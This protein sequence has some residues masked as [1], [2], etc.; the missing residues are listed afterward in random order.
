MTVPT[1]HHAPGH[2][3]LAILAT[4]VMALLFLMFESSFLWLAVP[5]A[6]V[7]LLPLARN[8]WTAR[9][10]YWRTGAA[11]AVVVVSILIW[12]T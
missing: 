1:R 3:G 7:T 11:A 9:E 12:I 5:I 8:D 4:L 2:T 6:V 10:I